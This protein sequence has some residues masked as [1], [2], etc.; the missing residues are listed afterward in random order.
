MR[1]SKIFYLCTLFMIVHK[2][3][4]H[5]YQQALKMKED[6]ASTHEILDYL[7]LSADF[8]GGSGIASSILLL[9]ASGLLRNGS[10]PQLPAD[11]LAQIDGLKPDP[12][13]GTCA[14]A[15]ATGQI[16]LT[17]DFYADDK[18]AELRHLPI[19]LGY[20]GAWSMPIKTKDGKVLGTFGTYFREK[21][22]PSAEEVKAVELLA[23]AAS[24]VLGGT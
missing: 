9:D 20:A 16:V 13:V 14:A 17:P 7:T 6:G 3:Y 24:I 5:A 22:S 21:R 18:W 8:A 19:A 10:S 2:F 4:T 15:A 23:S 11:Y 12:Q 1:F